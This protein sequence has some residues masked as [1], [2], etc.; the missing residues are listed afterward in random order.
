MESEAFSDESVD[1]GVWGFV[2][3]LVAGERVRKEEGDDIWA[4]AGDEDMYDCTIES[5]RC[6]KPGA[7]VSRKSRQWSASD[8]PRA[9]V[10]IQFIRRYL[11]LLAE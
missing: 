8:L 1:S 2:W 11:Q 5:V 6:F 7:V 4:D 3:E 9:Y 10:K